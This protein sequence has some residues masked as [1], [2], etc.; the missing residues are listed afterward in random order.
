MTTQT[1]NFWIEVVLF[2]LIVGSIAV[3]IV[4]SEVQHLD[5]N[6]IKLVVSDLRSFAASGQQLI[7]QHV[8]GQLTETFFSTQ[9]ELLEEKISTSYQTLLESESEPSAKQ[10]QQKAIDLAAQMDSA[11]TELRSSPQNATSVEQRL[12]ELETITKQLEERLKHE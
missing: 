5:N 9:V 11:I 7:A 3:A 2:V 1:R 10:S 8:A 4:A 6:D 12:N